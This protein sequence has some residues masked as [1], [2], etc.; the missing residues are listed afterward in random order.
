[1]ANPGFELDVD[2]NSRPDGWTSNSAFTRSADIA[3]SGTYSGK[4]TSTTSV[5]YNVTQTITPVIAGAT[6]KFSGW[7]NIPTTSGAFSFTLDV[8]WRDATGANLS[9]NTIKAY[10]AQTAGWDQATGSFVAPANA[11][12][13]LVRMVVS[14]LNGTVYVDDFS[15]GQ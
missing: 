10:T 2:N 8:R 1:M 13:A 14:T 6:Y 5:S 7:V 4:H 12:S 3:H 15:F 11:A 9:T